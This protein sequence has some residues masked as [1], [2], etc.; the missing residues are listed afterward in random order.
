LFIKDTPLKKNLNDG[1]AQNKQPNHSRDSN[2]KY[3]LKREDKS[4]FHTLNIALG[5][6]FG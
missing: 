6:Q 1:A 4:P 5:S 2:K 3:Q